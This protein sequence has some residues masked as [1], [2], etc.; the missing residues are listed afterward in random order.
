MDT[1]E[2][3]GSFR[4]DSA[5]AVNNVTDKELKDYVDMTADFAV[6]RQTQLDLFNKLTNNGNIQGLFMEA[7]GQI[8]VNAAYIATGVLTSKDG[9]S[10]YLDLDTGTFY[11]TGRFMSADGNS[12]ITLEGSEFVL[13][14]RQG[15]KDEFADIARIGFTED[16]DGVDYPYITMGSS[17]A[18]A[19][20]F[21]KIGLIKMFSNGLYIGNS[22]PRDSTGSFVGLVGASGLFVDTTE[23][24]PYLV[25]GTTLADA[26]E[27]VFA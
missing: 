17:N 8:Y 25:N 6:K 24:R 18:N 20:N 14:A 21:D 19:A 26:F 4:R 13:Y 15:D 16:T 7:D 1:I 22:A 10:F 27:C 9:H 12:Y 11:S 3:T 5:G 23:P 2:C